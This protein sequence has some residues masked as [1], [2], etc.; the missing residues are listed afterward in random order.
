MQSTLRISN[1]A[2]IAL[3]TAD[4]LAGQEKLLSPAVDI[5]KALDVSYNHLSKVLQQLTKAGLLLPARGPK[6][7]FTLSTAGKTA[8]VMDFIV[9]ID[10]RP[11]M[12]ACLLKHKVCRHRDCIFGNFLAE[13][14]RR[15]EAV[16]N[17][18]ISELSKR[19]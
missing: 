9:A 11:A 13:T 16:L 10:G 6:G 15:F 19:K 12:S 7:G 4:Y 1:A 17:R 5:A 8:K 14:N 2:V 18:G 3:H